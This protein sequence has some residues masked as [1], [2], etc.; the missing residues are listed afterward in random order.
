MTSF[1]DRCEQSF[2]SSD[3]PS[4]GEA[5]LEDL[6][7]CLRVYR[8]YGIDLAREAAS[9]RV[10]H[11]ICWRATEREWSEAAKEFTHRTVP[12][13]SVCDGAPEEGAVVRT[14]MPPRPRRG[15]FK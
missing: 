10:R 6:W 5:P 3:P 12:N 11:Y 13:A 14:S 9:M 2:G 15:Q 7:L 1:W 4:G 8:F